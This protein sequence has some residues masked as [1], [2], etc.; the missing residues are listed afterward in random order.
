MKTMTFPCLTTSWDD[1]HPLD[2]R[3]ADLLSKYGLTGTFYIPRYCQ[4]PTM[5][6]SQVRELSRYFEI[7]AHTMNHVY[8][9]GAT[10]GLAKSEIEDSRKWIEQTTEKPCEMFCPPGGKF[11]AKHLAQMKDAGY[12]AVRT[13]EM[14]SVER[15]SASDDLLLMPTTLQAHPH[16]P[17]VYLRNIFKRKRGLNLWLFLT[18]GR[19][20][21]WPRLAERL[22]RTALSRDG[23]FHLWG[24]SWEIQE[25][26]QWTQLEDVLKLMSEMRKEAPCVT[27]SQISRAVAIAADA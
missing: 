23:V 2:F 1:G 20:L 11:N 6:E 26:Q 4:T 8:L 7:G 16:L 15:P 27:N 14:I 18:K 12:K 24:H 22:L 25:S 10:D 17:T 3:I 13:V 9:D 19:T 21:D 5:N